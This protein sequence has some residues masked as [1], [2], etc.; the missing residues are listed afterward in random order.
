[1]AVTA[2][3]Q[4][5]PYQIL[6]AIGRVGLWKAHDTKLDSISRSIYIVT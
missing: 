2:G 1:M 4:L 5:G 3:T 6:S